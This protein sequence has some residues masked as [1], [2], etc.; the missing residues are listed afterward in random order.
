MDLLKPSAKDFSYGE[1][2]W[3][4]PR[5]LRS[6][7]ETYQPPL[8]PLEACRSQPIAFRDRCN[9]SMRNARLLHFRSRRCYS[10][11][12][13]HQ[14]SIQVR[15]WVEG[16]VRPLTLARRGTDISQESSA[17]TQHSAKQTNSLPTQSP[18]TKTPSRL[19]K[20]KTSVF[21]LW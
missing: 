7:G 19:P 16:Q 21:V 10:T 4:T 13:A 2:P 11:F 9:I 8:S 5:L 17:F 6:D 20:G 3:G 18:N 15:L 12:T 1:G 14:S